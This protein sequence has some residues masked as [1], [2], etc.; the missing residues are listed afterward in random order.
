MTCIQCDKRR[1][2]HLRSS[3][4]CK[5]T[6][7]CSDIRYYIVEASI[8]FE[9][10]E[11][12]FDNAHFCRIIRIRITINGQSYLLVMDRDFTVYSQSEGGIWIMLNSTRN[13]YNARMSISFDEDD[14][15]FLGTDSSWNR[16]LLTQS[17]QNFEISNIYYKG[18]NSYYVYRGVLRWLLEGLKAGL[19]L[20]KVF[21]PATGLTAG[22]QLHR[23]ISSF[24]VLNL[25]AVDYL[26]YPSTVVHFLAN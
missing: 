7:V 17:V 24:S 1:N 23:V 4:K 20:I 26:M 15:V 10:F 14:T 11:R 18:E 22:L 13:Y 12:I 19:L 8:F 16:R 5:L 2:F 6:F 3:N 21:A 25:L 9:F